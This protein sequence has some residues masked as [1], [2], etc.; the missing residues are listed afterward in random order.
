MSAAPY[1]GVDTESPATSP[2]IK[3]L[4]AHFKTPDFWG[5][6]I[7]GPHSPLTPSEI[8]LL[9][10]HGIKILSLYGNLASGSNGV[11]GS[12]AQGQS[13]AQAANSAAVA[14]GMPQGYALFAD[15]EASWIMSSDWAR[16]WCD[17][18]V[19][20]TLYIPGFYCAMNA[21][22]FNDGFNAASATDDLVASAAIWASEY[23]PGCHASP[24]PDWILCSNGGSPPNCI[25]TANNNLT[26]SVWQYA[27]T[28]TSYGFDEDEAQ[29][30]TY[31]W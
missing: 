1:W 24:G 28:C 12:Y 13:D 16:G 27:E 3:Y 11:D 5:R 17:Y 25:A 10:S 20:D 14:V 19:Q 30:V 23:E 18:M 2:A 21:G 22:N 6:Y 26:V 9:H 31:A 8:N 15:I 7:G 4:R 29:T